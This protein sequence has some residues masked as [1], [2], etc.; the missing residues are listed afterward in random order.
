[1]KVYTGLDLHS[2]NC[3]LG[4]IDSTG[5]KVFKQKLPND[6]ERILESLRPYQDDI[7]G[8]VVESTYN[9]YWLVDLLMETGYRV[10]LANPA[11]IKK[12]SGLKF[13]D[14]QH[15]AFWLAEMLRLG[16]LPEGYIYPKADRPIR[17]LLRKRMHLVKLRTS[18]IV[19]L[20]NIL[21]RNNGYRLKTADVKALCENRIAPLLAQNE[22]LALTGMVSKESI[23]HLTRQIKKIEAVIEDRLELKPSYAKLQSVFGV[24][25]ILALTIMLETGPISRFAKV[26]NYASYC[27][28]VSSKWISNERIKGKGN[29]KS[30]N[31]YLAWAYSEAAEHARRSYKEARAYYARKMQ[32]TNFMAA[33]NA[34]AHKLVRAAYY[35]MRDQVDFAPEKIFG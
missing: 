1:M 13:A 24:G 9:W 17:D 14:D 18:L 23:D 22:D 30:G 33:H 25:K 3:Y 32:K 12:Y 2:S 20:Q 10:H 15:D 27:R 35:V 8:I 19:S 34:L 31:K 4:I 28:K 26:G 21:S 7:V 11:A 16:I 6:R 29:T 5:K